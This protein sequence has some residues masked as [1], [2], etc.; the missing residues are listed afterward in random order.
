MGMYTCG[1]SATPSK[2]TGGLRLDCAR[3]ST[4]R[5]QNAPTASQSDAGDPIRTKQQRNGARELGHRPA[6]SCN[7]FPTLR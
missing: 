4:R 5:K 6:M 7:C 3:V 1:F 2:T